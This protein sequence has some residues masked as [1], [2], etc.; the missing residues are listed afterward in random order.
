MIS[1][2]HYAVERRRQMNVPSYA[3]ATPTARGLTL[4]HLTNKAM[5]QE[6]V[7]SASER[8]NVRAKGIG[9]ANQLRND[10]FDY[11]RKQLGLASGISL[12]NLGLTG[13]RAYETNQQQKELDKLYDRQGAA[14]DMRYDMGRQYREQMIDYLRKLR[15]WQ[16]PLSIPQNGGL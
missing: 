3:R 13:Y 15:P 10:Q 9:L 1:D 8:A 4:A 12:A 6:R 5:A 16:L 11:D 7:R 2:Y 14:M